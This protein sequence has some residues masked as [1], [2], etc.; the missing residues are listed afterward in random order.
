M[1][2]VVVGDNGLIQGELVEAITT[3]GHEVVQVFLGTERSTPDVGQLI[4]LL[5]GASVVVDVSVAPSLDS[6]RSLRF[7]Q[8]LTINLLAAELMTGVGHHVVLSVRGDR[9]SQDDGCFHAKAVQEDLVRLSPVPY[10]IVHATRFFEFVKSIADLATIETA[11]RLAPAVVQPA[12]ARNVAESLAAIA[13]GE[14]VNGTVELAG[15]DHFGIIEFVDLVLATHQEPQHPLI[16]EQALLLAVEAD[17]R[18]V[19]EEGSHPGA[20]PT[21][22][23]AGPRPQ[24]DTES[25]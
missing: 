10:S 2:V 9:D 6:A 17:R 8:T 24:R 3:A 15:S 5:D 21:P 14:P 18:V 13:L 7:H 1:K 25:G 22:L 4:H 20:T 19:P 16:D 11:A 12:A 23:Q